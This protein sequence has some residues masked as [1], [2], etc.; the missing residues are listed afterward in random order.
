MPL[1][2]TR[3]VSKVFSRGRSPDLCAVDR[4]TL[5]IQAGE[6]WALTGPSGSGKST[7]LALLGAIER[8][9]SGEVWF[10][11]KLLADLSDIGL[12][13]IRRRLGFV[14]QS[15]ALLPRLTVWENV[16][17]AL[18]PRGV[19]R[20]ERLAAAHD[21][22]EPLGLSQRLFD[23]AAALS[24]GEQQRVALARALIGKPAAL[25]ADEPTNQLDEQS[26]EVVR[27]VF[28][29]LLGEGVTLV[30]ATHD[31]ALE[32]LATNVAQMAAGRLTRR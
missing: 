25:L 3:D 21:A 18:V 29:R 15:F 19:P 4:A 23:P 7:L 1:F 32:R 30:L 14:F 22:L 20:R 17:Y 9:T 24:G 11:G 13:G 12:A 8:P 5:A 31:P 27:N 6:C 16:S 28:R 10:D 26:A 2:E